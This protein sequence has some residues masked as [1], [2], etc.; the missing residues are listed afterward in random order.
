M[1]TVNPFFQSFGITNNYIVTDEESRDAILIDCTD[2]DMAMID[3]IEDGKY[4]LQG[5]FLTHAHEHH[6]SGLLKLQ[7]IYS[8][9]VFSYLS[10]VRGVQTVSLAGQE[11]AMC[12]TLSVRVLHIPGHSPD[13]LVYLIGDN[14]F[15]GD[16]K[17]GA[18]RT[19]R[20]EKDLRIGIEEKIMS[21]PDETCIYPG[22]GPASTIALEKRFTF[23][24]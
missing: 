24:R 9:K 8:V 19:L 13:S 4:R 23:F 3:F 6:V 22:H 20:H 12:G 7:R 15:A 5:V 11:W 21:L 10:S 2:V 14:V 1:I 17:P 16:V 18:G